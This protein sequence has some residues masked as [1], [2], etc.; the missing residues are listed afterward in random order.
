MEKHSERRCTG[1]YEVGTCYRRDYRRVFLSLLVFGAALFPA[2]GETFRFQYEDDEQYR[3]ISHVDEEVYING[4][5]SHRADILNRI[6]VSVGDVTDQTGMLHAT[7]QTSERAY[8]Q[9]GVYEW[10]EEYSSVYRR[11]EYGNYGIEDAYF[12]PVVRHVPSFPARDVEI[13]ETWSAF[14]EEVHDFRANFGV[15]EAY[16]FPIQVGYTYVRKDELDD[17]PVDVISIN[18]TVFHKAR[19]IAGVSLYPI[20]ITGFSEQILYW[21]NSVGR[22]YHYSEEFD[23]LVTLS[24]G[25]SVEYVGVAEATVIEASRMNKVVIAEE[26]REEI[27]NLRIEDTEVRVSEDGITVSLQNIQ[28]LPDSAILTESEIAKLDR[29]AEIIGNYPDRD[30]LITGHTALAGTAEGRLW[31]SE[32]RARA[33]GEQF[34]DAGVRTAEQIV[35]RGVGALEPIADNVTEDGRRKNRR[36]EITILEN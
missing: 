24:N 28:F 7:F 2:I 25:I 22:P 34:L 20:M 3:I 16:R 9:S 10:A 6:T 15:S 26:I 33:V 1:Y 19:P 12:M 18:Y 21:D 36:V 17:R 30:I 4:E 32:E 13:G 29:I 8:G 14:G 31:L 35:T 11:D 23:F 27:E 5:Y